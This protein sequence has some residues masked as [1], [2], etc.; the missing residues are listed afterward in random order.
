MYE[1]NWVRVRDYQGNLL[2]RAIIVLQLGWPANFNQ[3]R[4]STVLQLYRR[5]DKTS[6]FRLFYLK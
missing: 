2:V 3:K 5:F 1:H 6:V 4:Q